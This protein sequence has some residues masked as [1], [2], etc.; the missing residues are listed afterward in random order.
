M[1][2]SITKT[3]APK[4]KPDWHT[5]KFGNT[6]TDHM[7]MMDYEEGRGWHD[8]RI[9]P[10]QNISLD[11]ASCV[12]HY[13]V[14]I[15]EGMK[16]YYGVD[17]KIRLFRPEMNAN[18]MNRSGAR[19]CMPEFP[20]ADFMQALKTLVE[21]EKD[22]IPTLPD[23][24]L[25]IRPVMIATE[26]HLGV[27]ISKSYL[28]YIMLSPV[29][30]Y[31]PEGL[32]PVK[33]F[34]EDEYVRAVKGGTG[35][36]KC[37]GNYA[38]SLIGQ[39]KAH[40]LGYSQVLW[41]DGEHHQYIDEVGTM[42]V[43]F[44]INGEVVTPELTGAILPGVTRDSVIHML[45]SWGMKVTER[46]ISLEELHRA[47]ADGS[48]EEAFGTGTAAVISPIGNLDIAGHSY[49][50]GDGGIGQLSQ[51]LYDSLTGIQWGKLKDEFGWT[52]EL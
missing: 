36:T 10:Y 14:E 4:A 35:F 23:T 40:D 38:A 19:L 34:V 33:I 7:F 11:P 50:V 27:S 51:K 48:L 45:K 30:A 26:P 47:A 42:N 1:N 20:V 18:R 37:G 6:F 8:A 16:A 29:G 39:K 9:V 5:L 43:M 24:S 49:T 32:N 41:L 22:W 52:V 13:A 21:L 44:K 25:Y 2:I 12:F 46:R 31:Y 28:F 3:T 17:G 15:F